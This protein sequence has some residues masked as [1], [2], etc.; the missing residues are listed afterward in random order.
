M[1]L[2]NKTAAEIKIDWNQTRYMHNQNNSGGFVFAGIGPG[3]AKAGTIPADKVGAG[4]T[5]QREIAP[6]RLLAFATMR[7]KGVA[8]GQSGINA[9]PVPEGR[10]GIALVLRV[11]GMQIRENLAV[12]IGRG[13]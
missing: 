13:R 9:G 10:N 8:P 11:D 3:D 6:Q 1:T 5:F 7:D 12:N 2:Q 4:K